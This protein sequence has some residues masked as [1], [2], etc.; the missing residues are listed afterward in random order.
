MHIV[1]DKDVVIVA[2]DGIFD[3]IFDEDILKC[4]QN[5]NWIKDTIEN[6]DAEEAAICLAERAS[7]LSKD[8]DYESPFAQHA[9]KYNKSYPGGKV[10]DITVIVG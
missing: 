7:A 1:N 5:K 10:D 8:K 6:S 3:N 4:L 2:S 9:K